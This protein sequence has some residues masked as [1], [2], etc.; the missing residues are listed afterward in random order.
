MSEKIEKVVTMVPD[1]LLSFILS[2]G[3]VIL[4]ILRLMN[5]HLIACTIIVPMTYSINNLIILT[6]EIF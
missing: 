4:S 5:S 1:I 2:H 6:F 3:L